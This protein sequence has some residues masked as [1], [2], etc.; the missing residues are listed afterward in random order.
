MSS[1]AARARTTLGFYE[2]ADRERELTRGLV[3]F[4][5]DALTPVFCAV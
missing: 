2:R 3:F 1:G 5:N 4:G